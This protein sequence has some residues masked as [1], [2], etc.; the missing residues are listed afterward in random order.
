LGKEVA[1]LLR[2]TIKLNVKMQNIVGKRLPPDSL[3]FARP[4]CLARNQPTQ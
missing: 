2:T 4:S 3:S 1:D